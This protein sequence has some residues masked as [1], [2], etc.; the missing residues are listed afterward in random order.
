M[1]NGTSKSGRLKLRHVIGLLALC[2]PFA[3]WAAAPRCVSSHAA[4]R[5]RPPS[6]APVPVP[7]PVLLAG[8]P[9]LVEYP[10]SLAAMFGSADPV[11][12]PFWVSSFGPATLRLT[13]TGLGNA[14]LL[15]LSGNQAGQ[16]CTASLALASTSI[17][18]VNVNEQ[19]RPVLVIF[20]AGA[21]PAAAG[22][23]K[24]RLLVLRAGM[25]PVEFPLTLRRDDY[26]PFMKAFLWF[27]GIFVPAA[28][29]AIFGLCVYAL[30]KRVDAK[31]AEAGT[32]Q[33]FRLGED[34]A[35]R[36]FFT[37][38]YQTTMC[39][40]D[41]DG[42]FVAT[43]ERELA[44]TRITYV[45]PQKSRERLLAALRQS[46]R[47]KLANELATAFPSFKEIILKPLTQEQ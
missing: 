16:A 4:P 5:A 30:Q 11:C 24:G 10:N 47:V 3:P 17:A 46:N 15:E 32:L 29:A 14:R 13:S 43:M 28:M 37:K 44:A 31:G 20:P 9:A 22:G 34:A 25:A 40:A 8:L 23:A 18:L 33:Q 1:A 39:L 12:V 26:S 2:L 42:D 7:A 6:P 35:L 21:F 38:I 27:L 19:E 41:D 36:N 45:L